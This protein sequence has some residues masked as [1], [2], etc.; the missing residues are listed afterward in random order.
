M[1]QHGLSTKDLNLSVSAAEVFENARQDSAG[2]LFAPPPQVEMDAYRKISGI[3]P[4]TAG[5]EKG[6]KGTP[7][8]VIWKCKNGPRL[9]DDG[10]DIVPNTIYE[11]TTA[12]AVL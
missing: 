12:S 8:K 11:S 4:A 1:V 10:L 6:R 2:E 3:P 9:T 7:D 5:V